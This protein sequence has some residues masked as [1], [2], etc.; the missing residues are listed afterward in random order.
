M[1]VH[2][3][4]VKNNKVTKETAESKPPKESLKVT[5]NE[6][7]ATPK[8]PNKKPNILHRIAGY[9]TGAWFELKQVRWPNRRQTWELTLAVILFSLLLGGTIFGLDFLFTWLF[10]KV[11]L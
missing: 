8:D 3:F 1:A 7:S 2:K 10:T 11:I 4:S 9:F 6:K 5:K